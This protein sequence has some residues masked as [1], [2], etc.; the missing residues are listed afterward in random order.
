MFL[1]QKI[2]IFKWQLELLSNYDFYGNRNYE[3]PRK[4]PKNVDFV[5]Q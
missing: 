5:L 4:I 3:N 2:N 1:F